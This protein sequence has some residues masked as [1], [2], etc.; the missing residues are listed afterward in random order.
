MKSIRILGMACSLLSCASL[1]GA[2][3]QTPTTTAQINTIVSGA[4]GKYEAAPD[5]AVLH[6]DISSQQDTSRAAYERVAAAADQVRD[7]LRKSG[8]DPKAAQIGFYAVQ[9]VYDWKNPKHRVLGYRVTTSVTLK[10]R[11][12]T[13]IGPILDQLSNIED[14]QNQTMNYTLEEVD[15][16]KAKAAGGRSLGELL[17]ASVD[18]NQPVIVPLIRPNVMARA[19]AAA[20]A[21]PTEDFT[22]QNVTITAHVN[23]MF[24]LK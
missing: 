23:A 5:T 10:L 9:P 4:E 16:A 24:A 17:Y 18:V 15:Q 7:V 3:A 1:A 2:Q 14:T 19:T 21:A 6:L 8:L 11:D 22:P 20:E 13:K 12:F